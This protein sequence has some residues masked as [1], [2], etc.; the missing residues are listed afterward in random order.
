MT[1]FIVPPAIDFPVQF[2]ESKVTHLKYSTNGNT[3][4]Y[5]NAVGSN[6]SCASHGDFYRG[7]YSEITSELQPED[8]E[9]MKLGWNTARSGGWACLDMVLPA[10]NFTLTTRQH[11]TDVSYRIVAPHGVDGTCS[12]TV[13]YGGIECYCSNGQMLGD[14]ET[15]RRKNSSRFE[16]SN[17]LTE[18]RR[19]KNDFLEHGRRLQTWAD[20]QLTTEAV[21]T[22]LVGMMSKRK[23]AKMLGLYGEEAIVRGGNVYALYSAFT[24]YSTYAGNGHNEFRLRRT[25]NDTRAVT[26]LAREVEVTRW[27]SSEAFLALAA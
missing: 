19:S 10:V 22:A 16:L 27:T 20:K 11:E 24:N 25:A 26:M 3:G 5:L 12:N 21:E 4:E 14:F 9:G 15:V 6:F 2:E 23:A 17:F 7:V 18:L 1:E 13:F 8:L